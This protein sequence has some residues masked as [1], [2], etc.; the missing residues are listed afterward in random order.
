MA[1]L[2]RLAPDAVPQVYD[3]FECTLSR[4]GNMKWRGFAMELA[5]HSPLQW[6]FSPPRPGSNGTEHTQLTGLT[7]SAR[8]MWFAKSA[9]TALEACHSIGYHHKDVKFNNM[10]VRVHG[11]DDLHESK[12]VLLDFGL[13]MTGDEKRVGTRFL[14]MEDWFDYKDED[15]GMRDRFAV[16]LTCVELAVHYTLCM[17]KKGAK[18][19]SAWRQCVYVRGSARKIAQKRFGEHFRKSAADLDGRGWLRFFGDHGADECY[20]GVYNHNKYCTKRVLPALEA[21]DVNELGKL[22]NLSW[23]SARG[24]KRGPSEVLDLTCDM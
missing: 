4:T 18:V 17:E 22:L 15:R 9:L 7:L 12:I 24:R 20:A 14:R 8:I 23:T 13:A 1:A 19:W 6:A 11:G 5:P 3:K 10:A 2:S 16:G 21:L